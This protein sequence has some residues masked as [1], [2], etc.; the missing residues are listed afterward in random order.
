MS[1]VGG[2]NVVSVFAVQTY[3]RKNT[4]DN[5]AVVQ[6]IPASIRSVAVNVGAAAAGKRGESSKAAV[7][8]AMI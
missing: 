8:I 7:N 3:A 1:S 2:V 5:N 6:N 4:V